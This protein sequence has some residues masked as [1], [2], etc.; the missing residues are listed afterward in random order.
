MPVRSSCCARSR[1]FPTST[2]RRCSTCRWAPS[3]RAWHGRAR[4]WRPNFAAASEGEV[5]D[6]STCEARVDA[7]VDGELSATESAAFEAALPGCPD[8]RRRLED[9]RAMSGFLRDLPAERAPDLLRARIERELRAISSAS[10]P[11]VPRPAFGQNM[12]WMATAASLI[13]A[14]SIGWVGGTF[15]GRPGAGD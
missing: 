8:C 10:R 1:I 9:T 6:C 13:V 15:T 5:M 14:V 7:Y 11:A 2:S 12:R 3:C 4:N